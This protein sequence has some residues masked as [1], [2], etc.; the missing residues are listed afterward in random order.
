MDTMIQVIEVLFA[1]SASQPATWQSY[2]GNFGI[3][4]GVEVTTGTDVIIN[5][6]NLTDSGCDVVADASFTGA[7]YL[8]VAP[9]P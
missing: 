8:I 3:T 2:E 9:R 7:V 6:E 4:H 1:A 5:V